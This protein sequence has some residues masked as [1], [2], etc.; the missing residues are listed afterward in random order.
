MTA[1]AHPLRIAN[2][3]VAAAVFGRTACFPRIVSGLARG[4]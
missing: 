2:T 4:M 1:V 3:A